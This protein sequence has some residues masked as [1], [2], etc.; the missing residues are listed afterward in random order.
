MFGSLV[1]R[2]RVLFRYFRR[3][4]VLTGFQL[5]SKLYP[6]PWP[7]HPTIKIIRLPSYAHPI[8]VRLGTSD[9]SVF[10]EVFLDQAYDLAF[11]NLNPR[12][13]ID[14]GANVGF[15]SIFLAHT[16]PQARVF[17][18]EPEKSNFQMLLTN[19][20]SCPSIIPVHAALWTT[21][22]KLQ[23]ANPNAE[24]WA[25]QVTNWRKGKAVETINALTI[26]TLLE[27]AKTNVI[28]ILKLDIEGAEIELFSANYENW[29]QKTNV[30]IM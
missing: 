22:G 30:I 11:L 25:F 28:D 23:I 17:S 2:F 27:L 14:G 8:S 3:F 12:V 10:Q 7:K 20:K 26:D 18:I 5:F 1:W 9:L 24:K 6:Y 16:Y 21:E 15:T 4:G 13:I 19:A 29:L